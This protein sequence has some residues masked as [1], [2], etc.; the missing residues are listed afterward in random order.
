MVF[1]A[2][3]RVSPILDFFLWEQRLG[4]VLQPQSDSKV[5]GPSNHDKK[6]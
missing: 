1:S 5:P 3:A 2:N 4:D 6:F